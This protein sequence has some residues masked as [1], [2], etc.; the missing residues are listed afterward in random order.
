M[1]TEG[2]V[3][4]MRTIAGMIL[5][6]PQRAP[7]TS[8]VTSGPYILVS[9]V[10]RLF[11]GLRDKDTVA[12]R[13]GKVVPANR[14]AAWRMGACGL[15]KRVIHCFRNQRALFASCPSCKKRSWIR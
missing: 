10:L 11:E 8:N 13:R 2:W 7:P 6:A 9:Q 14:M 15:L 4:N 5:G 3:E 12:P 1:E